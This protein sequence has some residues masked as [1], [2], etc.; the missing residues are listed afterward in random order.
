[1]IENIWAMLER[2]L[3]ERNENEI[4]KVQDGAGGGLWELWVGKQLE[5]T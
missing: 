1:M 3:N 2:H 4:R 5:G